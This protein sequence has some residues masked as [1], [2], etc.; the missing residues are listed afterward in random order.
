MY[1]LFLTVFDFQNYQIMQ[2]KLQLCE[3]EKKF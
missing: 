2:R 3:I 1:K